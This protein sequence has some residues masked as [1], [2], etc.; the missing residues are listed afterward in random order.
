LLP[1]LLAALGE[2]VASQ[3]DNLD[4]AERLGLIDSVDMWM[5]MRQLRNQMVHEY[6]ED[7]AILANALQAGHSFV[8]ILTATAEAMMTEI[9]KRGWDK[10]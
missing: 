8:P 4:R 3:L 7:R 2:R 10:S 5:G 1:I 9:C 6:I